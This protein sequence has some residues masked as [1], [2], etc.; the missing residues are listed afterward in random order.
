MGGKST[1]MRQNALVIFM[2]Q[3]GS[4]V[5]AQ[6]ADIC[7][8]DKLFCRIGANDA[9]SKG[10]STFMVEMCETAAILAQAT[11]RSLI[12]LDEVGRGTSTYDGIAIAA[13][14]VEHIA[15]K[16]KSRCLFATHYHEL[17]QLS[18]VLP[19]V[20]NHTVAIKELN[21]EIIFLYSIIPGVADKSYGV[22]VARIA[23]LPQ[24]ILHRANLILKSL[25]VQHQAV[26]LCE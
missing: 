25:E 24:E 26:R 13:A 11:S 19:G 23:G 20:V 6:T 10:Q 16:I 1:F 14:C 18:S 8:V 4:F 2:A 17:T 9:L 5:P 22:H 7:M 15:K 21:E 12:I 3:V